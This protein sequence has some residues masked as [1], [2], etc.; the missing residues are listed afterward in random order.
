MCFNPLYLMT[1]SKRK[2]ARLFAIAAK[3]KLFAGMLDDINDFGLELY[4][5][6]SA[7]G[8]AYQPFALST[9]RLDSQQKQMQFVQGFWSMAE[10]GAFGAKINL[11]RFNS[12]G[13]N[14]HIFLHEVMHFYQDMLGVYFLPIQEQGV[15]PMT[16]D[17]PSA[18]RAF[19]FCEAWAE[20]EAIRTSWALREKGDARAWRGAMKSKDWQSLA[21]GYDA[22]LQ[23]GMDEAKAAATLFRAWYEGDHRAFYEREALKIY[24]SNMARYIDGLGEEQVVRDQ[25]RHLDYAKLLEHI[26]PQHLPRYLTQID[27]SDDVFHRAVDEQAQQTLDALAQRYDISNNTN[28]QDIKNGAPAYLWKRLR[29]SEVNNAQVPPS[30]EP[31]KK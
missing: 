14:A 30:P 31:E 19:L 29:I 2:R 20:V 21:R 10:Q 7:M 26:T 8:G 27:W 15:F 22:N 4:F 5:P 13:E 1:S 3:D 11:S 28:I 6:F 18:L 9:E 12:E 16:L 17:A 23:N 24:E 25:F